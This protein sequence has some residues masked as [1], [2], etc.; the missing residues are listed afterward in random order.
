MWPLIA[1]AG[2]VLTAIGKSLYEKYFSNKELEAKKNWQENVI[3]VEKYIS[4]QEVKI[5]EYTSRKNSEIDFHTL[6]N[7][8]FTSMKIADQ[9]YRLFDYSKIYLDAMNR[10]L[11]ITTERKNK[12]NSLFNSKIEYNKKVKLTEELKGLNEMRNQLFDDKDILNSQKISLQTK[13]KSFNIRT[14]SLKFQ[15]R[16]NCGQQGSDWYNRL[17]QRKENRK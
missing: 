16:D 10:N 17:E 9:A 3:K 5:S 2:V 11:K 14:S 7:V 12:I 13:L 1:L 15:I 8:H 6:T 4:D